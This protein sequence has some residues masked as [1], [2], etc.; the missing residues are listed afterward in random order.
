[1]QVHLRVPA[2]SANIG[3]GFDS[4][5]LALS[6]YNEAVMEEY[7]GVDIQSL[8]GTEIP[9][10]KGNLLFRSAARLYEICGRPLPGLRIRQINRI[11]Q[12][13]GL[14]SSSA[15]IAAGLVGA[16][17]LLGNPME[18]ESLVSLAAQ[19]EG[20][21]DNTTPALLGGLT[22]SVM[23]YGKVYYAKKSLGKD[24]SFLCMIPDFPVSTREA[25]ALLPKTIAHADAVFNLSRTALMVASLFSGDYHNVRIASKDRLYTPYRTGLI[26]HAGEI[27]EFCEQAGALAVFV[28]GAGPTIVAM[29]RAD[30]PIEDAV[31]AFF[32]RQALPWR[33]MTLSA[34]ND[35]TAACIK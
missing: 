9:Q 19:I 8:D 15:C 12:T 28:S 10:G 4:L 35:G 25:R 21:P 32:D 26:P 6:L 16:N 11:P 18:Q 29:T 13:R 2:S 22:V 27:I 17:T 1:M 34:D 33:T 5:G 31:R 7:D 20:H 3:A 23:E 14:G 24:L 30:T